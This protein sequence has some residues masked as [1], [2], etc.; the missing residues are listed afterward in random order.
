MKLTIVGGPPADYW[1]VPMAAR[2][3]VGPTGKSVLLKNITWISF[4]AE[5]HNTSCLSRKSV[6]GP[7]WL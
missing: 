7:R 3:W 5:T 2:Y 1:W 6:F 4:P